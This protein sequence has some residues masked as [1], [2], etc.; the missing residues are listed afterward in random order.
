MSAGWKWSIGSEVL[1]TFGSEFLLQARYNR[2][3]L[4]DVFQAQTAV[5]DMVI[6]MN[7][8]QAQAD[9][10][11]SNIEEDLRKLQVIG[12][13]ASYNVRLHWRVTGGGLTFPGKYIFKIIKLFT[14]T[15]SMLGLTPTLSL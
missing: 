12:L 9:M 3:A 5:H 13:I 7:A 4:F 15:V 2:C 14:C 1:V 10:R 11:V 6:D 8:R